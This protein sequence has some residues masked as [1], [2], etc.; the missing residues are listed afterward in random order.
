MFDA[1]TSKMMREAP[2]L[3]GLN[4]ERLPEDLTKAFAEIVAFRVR[5]GDHGIPN[6]LEFDIELRRFGRM[7][8][9]FEGM[10]ALNTMPSTTKQAAFVAAHAYQLLNLANATTT[11]DSNELLTATSVSHSL[12]ALVLFLIA[13]QPSDAAEMAREIEKGIPE[14]LSIVD[15]LVRTI[16]HLGSGRISSV[17]D[18]QFS[19]VSLKEGAIE[20]AKNSLFRHI[21]IG[22]QKFAR[23]FA[24]SSQ[25]QQYLDE[26]IQELEDVRKLASGEYSSSQQ[27]NSLDR[28]AVLSFPGPFHLATLLV[29][30]VNHLARLS[31]VHVQVPNGLQESSWHD[32]IASIARER[33][34]L[35]PNHIEAINSGFLQRG[36]S[37]AISFP[38]GAGKTTLSSLKIASGLAGGRA[39]IYLAP[40]NA[41]V[42]Q[43]RRDLINTFPEVTVSESLISDDF[44]AEV[45]EPW[46]TSSPKIAVMTPERCLALL[47]VNA[48]NFTGLGLIVFDE[49]HLLHP[50]QGGRTR[51]NIDAMLTVLL[52]NQ[53]APEAD[54]L[55]LSAMMA[56]AVEIADWLKSITERNCLAL[57]LN[58]KPTRQARGCL[59]YDMNT[60]KQVE[61]NLRRTSRLTASSAKKLDIAKAI[62]SV[63]MGLQQTWQDQKTHN[64]ALLQ[65]TNEPIALGINKYKRL[66]ANKNEVAAHIAAKCADIGL[67]VLAFAQSQVFVS[68]IAKKVNA[69]RSDNVDLILEATEQELLDLA[70]EEMGSIEAVIHP[71]GHAGQHHALLLPVERELVES[72]F[73]RKGSGVNVLA[74][75]ATL[76]QGINL[77]AD[78]VLIVGDQRFD[79]DA[80]DFAPLDPHE[81]LNAAGRAGRAGLVAQGI[82]IVIPHNLIGF[83]ANKSTIGSEWIRLQTTIFSKADQCLDILDPLESVLDR[84]HEA[85]AVPDA[86]TRYLLRRLP[87]VETDNGERLRRFLRS[88]LGGWQAKRAGLSDEF[89]QRIEVIT[90]KVHAAAQDMGTDEWL[91]DLAYRTGISSEF[92]V[93]LNGALRF[94]GEDEPT[95]IDDWVRWFFGWLGH[96]PKAIDELLGHRITGRQK[97]SLEEPDFFGGKLAE[98]VV[99]WTNGEPLNKLETLLVG[100]QTELGECNNA[101]KFVLRLLPDLAFAAGLVTQIRRWEIESMGGE[102]P[103][104]LAVLGLCVREGVSSPE[105]AA[106]LNIIASRGRRLSRVGVTKL[107]DQV[108]AFVQ[109]ASSATEPFTQ[110]LKRVQDGY[111]AWTLF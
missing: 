100:R 90:T 48:N 44:Y 3:D 88:S 11:T 86:E 91:R 27:E 38:T 87:R 42:S 103:T 92:I 77:P 34:F 60:L 57:T 45:D 6:Q 50:G 30:A 43:V 94:E 111:D 108:A 75:T 32:F 4:A 96:Q 80:D 67:S 109:P 8:A 23:Y 51:R 31:L 101:R 19:E 29:S 5:F 14:T 1:L 102:M 54:W 65:L 25:P 2:Q 36:T 18:I 37:A 99:G 56:N 39:V 12:A 70:T 24:Y 72:V 107:W 95:G 46:H 62:P 76:A 63:F 74:A 40:T 81:L 41:L 68:S 69:L 71:L 28:H 64:Y 17:L 47:S 82:V 105:K 89:E 26:A 33:P 85:G 98:A 15:Q 93:L 20:A 110:T 52:L 78:I 79:S 13:D 7:A 104:V 84:I 73:R 21:G 66:T 49:C 97:S 22:L 83:D 35:W 55:M 61:L 16:C 106:L 10:V 59:V 58:W 53:A 9:T